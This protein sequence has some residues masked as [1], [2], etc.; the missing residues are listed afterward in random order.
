VINLIKTPK[1]ADIKVEYAIDND[2]LIATINNTVETFDFAGLTEGRA[3]EIITD[4]LHI[5]PIISAE[6]IGEIVNITVMQFYGEDEKELFEG[7][8]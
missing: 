8:Q 7:V 2:V 3:E 5:N 6:K 1:R 4:T